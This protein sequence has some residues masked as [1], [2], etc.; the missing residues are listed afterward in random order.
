MAAQD[1]ALLLGCCTCSALYK[2]KDLHE[3]LS[4]ANFE[5]I[6]KKILDRCMSPVKKALKDSGL[7]KSK[8]KEVCF[9]QN[10]MSTSECDV[11]L[12]SAGGA[13]GRFDPNPICEKDAAKIF[14]QK[15]N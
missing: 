3:T 12:N 11:Y 9:T 7:S 10:T 13:R 4:R 14:W 6:S 15:K 2:G 8:I 1:I 5:E